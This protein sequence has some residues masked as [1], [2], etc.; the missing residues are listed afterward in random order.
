MSSE[1]DRLEADF[2]LFQLA[3]ERGKFA[4]SLRVELTE[5]QLDAFE[6][7]ISMEYFRLVDVAP[8]R[9]SPHTLMMCRVFM[10]TEAGE[11]RRREAFEAKG[12][13]LAKFLRRRT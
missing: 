1:A 3:N 10:L 2:S 8:V 7:G 12:I 4:I 11:L 13:D 5:D 9:T 6:R